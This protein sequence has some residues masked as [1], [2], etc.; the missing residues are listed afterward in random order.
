MHD[1]SHKVTVYSTLNG[2]AHRKDKQ[3]NEKNKDYYLL[4]LYNKGADRPTKQLYKVTLL[5][6]TN[7]AVI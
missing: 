4:C 7:K 1:I 5:L 2:W 6:K 3:R